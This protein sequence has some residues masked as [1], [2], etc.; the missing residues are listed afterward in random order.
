VAT[1][2]LFTDAWLEEC[3][4]A[5][6]GLPGPS[7]GRLVVTELITDAPEGAHHA[8]TLVADHEG[9]RLSA[10]DPG[11]ASAWLTISIRDAEALH[12]GDL[13]PAAAL[14]EGRL[15]VRGDLRS[16][17]ELAELLATAHARLRER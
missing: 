3:N 8:V 4:G 6:A 7:E 15:K 5:L 10:G 1:T 13:D 2:A 16:V 11:G 9:V 17:V 12:R 14:T